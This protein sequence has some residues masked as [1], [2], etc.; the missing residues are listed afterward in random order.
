MHSL[1][2]GVFL[3]QLLLFIANAQNST[4]GTCKDI[5]YA[6]HY[7][8]ST[9]RQIPATSLEGHNP[10]DP[11]RP[12]GSPYKLV[13]DSSRTWDLSLRVQRERWAN[14]SNM[15]ENP[16]YE[17]AM[18]LDTKDSNMTDIGTCHQT[19][20]ASNNPGSYS[21]TKAIMERS[22]KD[23]GDCSTLLG[24]ECVT[25]LK[26][27]YLGEATNW[28]LRAGKCAGMNSTMPRECSGFGPDLT[29]Q[30]MF[31]FTVHSMTRC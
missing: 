30:R 17:Q 2:N 12:N 5:D 29:T 26:K 14:S 6:L 13:Y 15:P 18:F 23:N 24:K 10:R 27:M 22:L 31:R 19:I 1:T 3:T 8:A 28:P 20:K 9:T 25:A 16:R 4:V 11:R 7:N 21:W